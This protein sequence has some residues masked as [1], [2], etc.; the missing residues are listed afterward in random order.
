MSCY[1]FCHDNTYGGSAYVSGTT[2]DGVVGAF[3]LTLG[4]CI[5]I[6]TTNPHTC[7]GPLIFSASC[8]PNVTPTTTPSPTPTPF[9]D[10]R[11]YYAEK[12]STFLSQSTISWT[13][14]DLAELSQTLENP[15]STY[16][17]N[18]TFCALAGSLSYDSAQIDVTDNGSCITPTPTKTNTPT[19]TNTPTITQTSTPTR[20]ADV[21]P[22]NTP[23]QTVTPTNTST[24]TQTP[25]PSVTIGLTPSMTASPTE[26]PSSTPTNTPTNTLTPTNTSTNTPTNTVTST[27]TSTPTNTPTNTQTTTPTNTPTPTSTMNPICPEQLTISGISGVLADFNGT[28]DRLHSYTGGTLEY[29]YWGNIVTGPFSANTLY[30]GNAYSVFLRVSGT[31]YYTLTYRTGSTTVWGVTR[32]SGDS[33]VNGAVRL[34]SAAVTSATTFYSGIGYPS[35]GLYSNNVYVSYTNPCPTPTPTQSPTN[36]ATNT[37]TP[38][39]TPTNTNTPTNTAT[40]TPTQTQ[41]PTP[42][43]TPYPVCPNELNFTDDPSGSVYY[44]GTYYRQ[45]S[46]TGGTFTGGWYNSTT[47]VFVPGADPSGNT[48]AVYSVQS[49]STYYNIIWY[50]QVSGGLNGPYVIEKT[51]GGTLADGG[52]SIGG[53]GLFGGTPILSSGVYYP[54][55]RTYGNNGTISYPAVCPTATPTASVTTTPTPTQ[56]KTPTPTP[57]SPNQCSYLTVANPTSLDIEITGVSVSGVPVTYISGTT[58]P[59]GAG[60]PSGDFYN[61]ITGASLTVDVTFTSSISGQNI[62]LLDCDEVT[63]CFETTGSSGTATF[64]TVNISCGCAW[65]ITASDGSCV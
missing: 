55:G 43:T 13:S 3:Y 26:T 34:N 31:D 9:G 60:D 65:T 5:C 1:S 24:Q 58:F 29:G 64:T 33:I 38:S 37:P 56:T 21:T 51:T 12:K 10:C 20:T 30:L 36:T 49:A 28:Y 52:T 23:T 7:C 53:S 22:T 19:P 4:D 57:T 48:Y 42:S 47:N 50:S 32:S 45:T 41:T 44:S 40:N 17:E 54:Q 25:T 15:P 27:S 2:C 63:H 39:I 46:Y 35:A 62:T 8:F 14:C 59:I 6:E 11:V 61:Q 16:P 18:I